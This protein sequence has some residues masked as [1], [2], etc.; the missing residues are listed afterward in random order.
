MEDIV[1]KHRE[2]II[3]GTIRILN[4]H[5]VADMEHPFSSSTSEP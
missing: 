3:A 4:A 2:I 5:L 1:P